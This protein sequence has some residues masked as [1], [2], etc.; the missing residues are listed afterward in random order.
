[1][2]RRLLVPLLAMLLGAPAVAY[3][4]P[5]AC[6]E[7]VAEVNGTNP[8][9]ADIAAMLDAAAD[10]H[11]T[12]KVPPQVLRAIAYQE[13]E[14]RQY[15]AD[16]DVVI[17]SDAVCGIGIMQVTASDDPDPMRL[18]TDVEYNIE[19]G[20]AILRD[21]WVLSQQL[22]NEP[23]DTGQEDDPTVTENWYYALCLYNGSCASGDAYSAR[24]AE[25]VA[26]PFRRVL[27]TALKPYLP[28]EGFTK[29][30]E[31]DPSYVFPGAF[32]AR[33]NPSVFVFYDN[34]TGAVTKTVYTYTHDY[35]DPS[36]VVE[37]GAATYGPDTVRVTC[38]QCG[39]WRLA[40]GQGIAGRAHWTNS[41]TGPAQSTMTWDPVLT[42]TGRY[43]VWAYVPDLGPLGTATYDVGGTPVT[44][45]QNAAKN[46]WRWL[47]DHTLSLG[48]KVTLTDH[49][50]VGGQRLAGDAVR[51]SGIPTLTV[52]PASP[53]ITYGGGTT[54]TIRLRHADDEYGGEPYE[55]T[56]WK[57]PV[58]APAWSRLGTYD[59]E[60]LVLPARPL[61]NTE[62]RVTF[63]SPYVYF[64]DAVSATRRVYVRPKVT[65]ALSRTSVPRGVPVTVSARVVPAHA[66]QRVYLQRLTS[67]GWQ[68]VTSKLLSGSGTAA[69]PVSRSTAGTYRYR[70]YKPADADH[71]AGAS[72]SLTL[73][74]T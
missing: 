2:T 1:V 42:G 52:T 9:Y 12:L 64:L 72:A 20:A 65:A 4:D 62:Y 35:R 23:A 74:V 59:P 26:D 43:R 67:S 28:I 46:T 55:V 37:Y 18:A 73:T 45:D 8:P 11:A 63:E 30:S 16:G 15:D 21:K 19:R 60:D 36:P 14:W 25:I 70:V 50:A 31:A 24:V 32:Q 49:S 27:N 3:A 44:I 71:V 47:G 34:G 51:V 39:G 6:P 13:S 56:L 7:G 17:S 29:P 38:T 54:L 69:F 48:D 58:G 40:E 66:G 22:S 5:A 10:T 61:V 68:N 57:R 53:T 41:V 33:L